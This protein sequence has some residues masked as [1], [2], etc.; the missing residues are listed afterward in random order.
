MLLGIKKTFKLTIFGQ[1]HVF[2]R[3]DWCLQMNLGKETRGLMNPGILWARKTQKSSKLLEVKTQLLLQTTTTFLC[4]TVSTFV[5]FRQSS[6]PNRT[7]PPSRPHTA[8]VFQLL[9]KTHCHSAPHNAWPLGRLDPP[10]IRPQRGIG[11]QPDGPELG[12][13]SPWKTKAP[14]MVKSESSC[15]E[16]FEGERGEDHFNMIQFGTP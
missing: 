12:P 16:D 3:C 6:K 1:L 4:S 9:P 15:E 2:E 10:R 5:R 7:L 14:L 13:L 8:S 11:P